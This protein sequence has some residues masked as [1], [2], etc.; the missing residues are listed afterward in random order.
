[1]RWRPNGFASRIHETGFQ[2]GGVWRFVIHGPDGT[3]YKNKIV[4]LE[5]QPPERLVYEDGDDVEVGYPNSFQVTAMF[6]SL[7]GKTRLTLRMVMASAAIKEQMIREV[8]TLDGAD[9]TRSRLEEYL[10]TM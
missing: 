10:A 9:Q 1:M 4:Y 3:D 8:G 6:E 5:V 7:G 2:P